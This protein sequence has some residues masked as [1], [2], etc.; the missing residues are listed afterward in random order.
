MKRLFALASAVVLGIGMIGCTEETIVEHP[1]NAGIHV[2]PQPVTLQETAQGG[3]ELNKNISF[4]ASGDELTE[5]ASFFSQKIK[6]STGFNLPTIAESQDPMQEISLQLVGDDIVPDAEGYTLDVSKEGGVL[7]QAQTPRGVFWGLQTLLQLLPAEIESPTVVRNVAWHIPFVSI[8]DAPRFGYR[9]MHLDPCRH[10]L[11]VDETKKFIDLISMLKINKLHWHL[12]EDQGWR[13]ESKVYP[14]LTEVGSKRIEGDGSTYGPYFY[15]REEIKDIVAYAKQRYVEVIPEIEFPGHNVAVLTA[16]PELGCWGEEFPY[17]VRNIW[18]ISDEVL[19]A[20]ND[21]VFEFAKNILDEII[22]LFD[23]EYIH[24]GG[25]EAPKRIWEQCPK[26]QARI[27]AE[28]LKDEYELQ[29]YFIH[30]IEEIVLSHGKKMIGWEEILEG[31]LAPTAIVMSWT[32]EKGGITSANMGHDVIMCPSSEGLYLD[33]YQ[34]DRYIEPQAIGGYSTLDKVY[35]Y[36]PIP[37]AIDADK[38]HHVLGVQ[39]NLWSE[40]FYEEWQVEYHAFPRIVAVAEV[41]WSPL[42]A[43]D[44]SDF[45][46]RLQNFQKRLDYHDVRYYIPQP[47][48]VGGSINKVAFVDSVTL[49][50]KTTNSVHKILYTIDG[51]EPTAEN[52]LEYTAPLTFTDNTQLNIRS[53]VLGGRMS[54]TRTIEIAKEAYLPAAGQLTD[55]GTEYAQGIRYTYKADHHFESVDAL[56]SYDTDSMTAV[57]AAEVSKTGLPFYKEPRLEHLMSNVNHYGAIGEGYINVPEDAVYRL[58]SL[59][60]RVWLDDQLIIDNEGEV[61]KDPRHDTTMALSAGLHKIKFVEIGE[62]V[63]GWPTFWSD[64]RLKWQKFGSDEAITVIPDEAYF[65]SVNK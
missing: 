25:D 40:Y 5:V 16:Y 26:C 9:G 43:K 55:S 34:G 50:F 3:F 18:G 29:S 41:G 6:A 24:I 65:H 39:G 28:G 51:T 30:K 10:F 15:T 31:G 54:P 38:R 1:Y 49:E 63:G 44:F 17:E 11:S 8:K 33:H 19:C 42:E 2:I 56:L 52:G 21:K 22:P 14:E 4:V 64:T 48:Q 62:I 37:E 7:V 32:G 61:L 59:Y 60:S 45:E 13:I 58:S 46:R 57:I 53:M 36:N 12:T 20:G 35:R 47:E 23:S 27:K